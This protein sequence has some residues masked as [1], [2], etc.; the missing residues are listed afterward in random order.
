MGFSEHIGAFRGLIE[1][2]LKLGAWKKRLR[3]DPA[4][5]M[6]AYIAASSGAV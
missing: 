2:R 1:G 6:E 4:R 3:D 5:I